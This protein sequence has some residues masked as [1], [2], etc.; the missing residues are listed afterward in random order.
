MNPAQVS[1]KEAA[2]VRRLLVALVSTVCH[3]PRTVLAVSLALCVLSLVAAATRLQYHTQRND[4]IS[5]DKDYQQRWRRY[6]DE[7]GDDDDIVVV[8]RGSDRARMNAA[9]EQMAARV[10]EKPELFD[11]LF[12]K[13]DLRHLRDRALLLLPDD[14]LDAIHQH[15]SSPQ[16]SM[17]LRVSA[18]WRSVGLEGM[19]L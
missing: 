13:A 5:A 17:L 12:Y 8:V 6:L 15:L 11:R 7:F 1:A 14:E 4:L 2:P 10:R 16:M 18:L 19:L 9:L 3:F